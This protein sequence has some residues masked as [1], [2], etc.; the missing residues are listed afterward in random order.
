MAAFALSESHKSRAL[1]RARSLPDSDGFITVTR[2]GRAGPARNEEAVAKMEE[3]RAKEEEKR[4]G[5]GGFY[6][7]QVRERKRAEAG[8]L[9]RR[10]REEGGRGEEG[11][12]EMVRGRRNKFKSA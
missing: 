5:M 9:V 1:A 3:L 6:R 2:G 10:F 8:E 7:F 4:R 11:E 12:G